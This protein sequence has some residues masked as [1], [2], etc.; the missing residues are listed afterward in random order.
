MNGSDEAHNWDAYEGRPPQNI[1]IEANETSYNNYRN[2]SNEWHAGGIKAVNSCNTV[3]VSQHQAVS[4]RGPGI[5]FDIWCKNITVDRSIVKKNT[6]GIFYEIS[7]D[8]LISNN[9]VLGN[10]SQGIYVAASSGVRV[11]NNTVYQ[12]WAGIVLHGMPRADHPTLANNTV[13]N[14]IVGESE[15]VDLVLY[16][17]PLITSGNTTDYNLYYHPDS[18]VKI[19]LTT[20]KGYNVNYRNLTVPG[21]E[22]HSRATNPLWESNFSLKSN[23]PA[24]NAGQLVEGIGSKD[25]AG[26]MRVSDGVIDIGAYEFHRSSILAPENVRLLN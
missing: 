17:D 19:S 9:L 10:T 7:D 15:L 5:W 2:F 14:N 6:A 21:N 26:L 13:R 11:L 16:S 1:L 25:L 22:Q 20:T 3:T 24:I 23:S 4:N 12:N 8:A 18:T